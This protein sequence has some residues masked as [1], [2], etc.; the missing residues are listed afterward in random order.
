MLADSISVRKQ[1]DEEKNGIS[2][3]IVDCFNEKNREGITAIL[4]KKQGITDIN[5]QIQA[6]FKFVKGN[7]VSY[8]HAF[9]DAG[10]GHSKE[11]GEI[12]KFDNTWIINDITTDVGEIDKIRVHMFVLDPDKN[13]EGVCCF[14]IT[15]KDGAEWVIGYWWTTYDYE[16]STLSYNAI[17]AISHKN[18]DAL[19]SLF[20]AEI[21]EN[22]TIENQMQSGFVFFEGEATFGEIKNKPGTFDGNYNFRGLV[23]DEEIIENHKP[24][25]TY[26]SVFCENIETDIDKTYQLELYAYLLYIDNKAYGGYFANYDSRWYKGMCDW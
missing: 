16:G 2:Q 7:I 4:C 14:C 20:C 15:S 11:N 1:A 23:N 9:E 22:S 19:K 6:G 24:I 26:V 3:K 13:C 21:L 25:R 8:H 18:S 5:E 10:E 17:K 12:I